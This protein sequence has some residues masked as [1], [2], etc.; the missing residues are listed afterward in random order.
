MS[1]LI[2]FLILFFPLLISIAVLTL[3]ERKVLGYT[4]IRKGPNIV[5][6]YG[7]LQPLADGVKLF[8]KEPLIPNHVNM[9]IF[10]MSPLLMFI[11]AIIVWYFIPFSISSHIFN[12]NISILIILAI[13]SISVFSIIMA[14]WGS[15]SK[16]GF[17]GSV[18]ATSQ[19]ISYEVSLGLIVMNLSI[20]CYSL[21]ILKICYYQSIYISLL[22][23]LLPVFFMFFISLIAETN[24]A[25]FDL[26]ESESELVSGY[27]I[28]YSGFI[29][30]LF[31]LGEYSHIIFSSYLICILFTSY[32]F[33][34]IIIK[35]L[36]II[37]IFIWIRSSFP[38]FRYDHLMHLLWK[39]YLPL[40]ILYFIIYAILY[41]II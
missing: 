31:F 37:F 2:K 16:Y 11:L 27:N 9:F 34:N 13:N 15:N 18:R 39:S 40:S 3:I 21:D 19:M 32:I 29:F 17:I 12:S 22:I 28:E 33:L 7:L 4:Q 20:I 10:I 26:S 41:V 38:R 23:P 6:L 1:K 35:S 24:R 25:P 30:A 36:I 8:L 5:G 14:G